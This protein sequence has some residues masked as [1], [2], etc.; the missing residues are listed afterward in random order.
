MDTIPVAADEAASATAS[1]NL[2]P[3]PAPPKSEVE[4]PSIVQQLSFSA[5]SQHQMQQVIRDLAARASA[6]RLRVS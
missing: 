2:V 4:S 5:P 3:V 1:N 6:R